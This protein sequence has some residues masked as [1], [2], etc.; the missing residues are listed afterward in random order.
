MHLYK[1]KGNW[2][3]CDNHRAISLLSIAGK[4]LARIILNHLIEH[5]ECSLL[6]ESQCVLRKECGT[7]DM[8]FAT[9]QLQETCQEQ[10]KNIYT[11]FFDLTKAFDTVSWEGL[12]KIMAK[13][14][15]PEK[16]IS[17]VKQFHEGSSW[18]L[19]RAFSS[20]KWSQARL[21]SCPYCSQPCSLIHFELRIL[22]WT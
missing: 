2:Q 22:A 16:F 9:C 15:C 14:S 18:W 20:Y 12:W 17:V 3:S 11:T 7:T 13:F 8:I 5:L 10:H 6:P 21:C 19:F 1:R 4:I